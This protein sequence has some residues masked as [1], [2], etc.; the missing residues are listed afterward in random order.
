M[1]AMKELHHD[2][3]TYES[4]YLDSAVE[5]FALLAHPVRVKLVLALRDIEMSINHLA[6]IVDLST[7]H[8]GAELAVLESAGIVAQEHE[9]RRD[10]YRLANEHAGALAANAIFHAEHRASV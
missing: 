10:F 8:A 9:G 1:I 2:S 7:E 3:A 5:V 4:P 6:D